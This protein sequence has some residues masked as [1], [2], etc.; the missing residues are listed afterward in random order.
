MINRGGL[1]L[2]TAAIKAATVLVPEIL[3]LMSGAVMGDVIGI[4]ADN[5]SWTDVAPF[6]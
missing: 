2:S 4:P 5:P 6:S 3:L 1:R